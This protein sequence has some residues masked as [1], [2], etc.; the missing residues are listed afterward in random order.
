METSTSLLER[1]RQDSAEADWQR[2]VALYTPLIRG[3]LRR[4][5]AAQQDADDLV[6]EVLSIVIRKLPFFERE[7]TG[8]FRSWLRTIS[9]NCLRESWRSKRFRPMASG[10][11]TFREVL[12]QLSDPE[13]ELS[14]LWDQEHDDHV[15]RELL[16]TIRPTVGDEIWEA[17]RRVTLDGAKPADVAEE[18]GTS[19]NAVYIAKSRVMSRLREEGRGLID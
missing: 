2:L 8:S 11:T 15:M 19:V 13:S 3:W 6:Q 16:Q 1:L 4:Y 18:L 14:R 17:F 10:G 7:R 5:S 12:E 9:V